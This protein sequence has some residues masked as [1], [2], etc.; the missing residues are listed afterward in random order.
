MLLARTLR[1]AQSVSQELD[2]RIHVTFDLM[3]LH[4]SSQFL[5]AMASS[6]PW[7]VVCRTDDSPN[8]NTHLGIV[9]PS[10]P[11]ML[12][13][14][15]LKQLN[16]SAVARQC[17]AMSLEISSPCCSRS[18]VKL[19]RCIYIKKCPLA[20]WRKLFSYIWCLLVGDLSYP[21]SFKMNFSNIS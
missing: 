8:F 12:L 20:V 15:C 10:L 1:A 21:A 9:D 7:I 11:C 4:Q 19:Q 2:A 13:H 6:L 18:C 5:T 3:T 14:P 16:C 17:D